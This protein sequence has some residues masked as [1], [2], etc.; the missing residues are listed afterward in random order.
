M[1]SP[2][3]EPITVGGT[4]YQPI[5]ANDVVLIR[6]AA[7]RSN[8]WLW[9]AFGPFLLSYGQSR[10]RAILIGE[11][12]GAVIIAIRRRIRGADH[13]DLVIPPLG[14][15]AISLLQSVAD[16]FAAYNGPNTETR[17]LWA[18]LPVVAS[19][20]VRAD[21]SATP[22]EHE[23]VYEREQVLGMA[24]AEYRMLRKRVNRCEREATPYVR[25]YVAAD[26]EACAELLREWQDARE[27]RDEPVFDFG[28]TLAALEIA[29]S[30]G[31]PD[32]VGVVLEVDGE[33]RAFAFGGVLRAGIGQFFVQK[34]DPS[35]V[36]LSE[37]TRVE[38]LRRL[39]GCRYVNDAG[40]LGHEGLAQHKRAFRPVAFV[41]T[42]KLAY[43]R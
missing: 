23:Y 10:S 3:H 22:Y 16:A 25:E 5:H 20:S 1:E 24:G 6:N 30:I 31:S 34:S 42:W 39:D 36:G 35:I 26:R 33:I 2:L 18:D 38:L 28:Y 9:A 19:V 12:G 4:L 41:P 11:S 43:R 15:T 17:V 7:E 27:S 37:T 14:D 21:W 8:A 29:E 32:L 40:D 13:L